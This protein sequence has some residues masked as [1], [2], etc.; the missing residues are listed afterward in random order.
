VCEAGGVI[1]HAVPRTGTILFWNSG[2]KPLVYAL[3]A[4]INVRVS[5]APRGVLTVQRA[6]GDE[7]GATDKT[8]VWVWR[9]NPVLRLTLATDAGSRSSAAAW[10]D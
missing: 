3:E 4:T 6:E 8:G 1:E 5:S 9:F 2:R 7:A 10:Y